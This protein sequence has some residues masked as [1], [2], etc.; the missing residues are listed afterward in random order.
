MGG[1]SRLLAAL[2]AVFGVRGDFHY[3]DLAPSPANC[4]EPEPAL[5]VHKVRYFHLPKAGSSFA[6]Q[7]WALACALGNN[8]NALSL[9]IN[10]NK[11]H[12]TSF[13]PKLTSGPAC[14]GHYLGGHAR[15]AVDYHHEGLATIEDAAA[16]VG[17][18]REPTSRIVSAFNYNLH[19]HRSNNAAVARKE[20]SGSKLGPLQSDMQRKKI[21]NLE[22]LVE[23]SKLPEVRNSAMKMLLGR[24]PGSLDPAG[25]VDRAQVATA[26]HR[27]EAFFFVGILECIDEAALLLRRL[28]PFD[29][30]PPMIEHRRK[31]PPP[32]DANVSVLL[33]VDVLAADLL[34]RTPHDA[35]YDADVEI[36]PLA[37]CEFHR[38][39]R[40]CN[41][42]PT[43]TTCQASARVYTPGFCTAMS[44]EPEQSRAPILRNR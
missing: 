42:P 1:G 30:P 33:Q 22:G 17:L 41:A 16:A 31:N 28:A 14:D 12:L 39:R 35:L 25:R 29:T 26:K 44:A 15:I 7:V 5:P 32:T 19:V 37:A 21:S 9:N 24:Y 8:S 6:P 4:T 20:S 13:S 27:L 34:R 10:R 40:E 43:S 38:R 2:A 23:F 3:Y 11:G 18:F 36:Y